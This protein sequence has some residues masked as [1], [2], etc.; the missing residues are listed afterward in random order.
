V[1]GAWCLVLGAWCLVLGAWFNGSINNG[2]L[3]VNKTRKMVYTGT[4]DKNYH[5]LRVG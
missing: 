4:I 5:Y 1:L 3:K 2:I